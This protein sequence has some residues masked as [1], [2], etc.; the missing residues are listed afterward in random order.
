MCPTNSD[1]LPECGACHTPGTSLSR[2]KG[3]PASWIPDEEQAQVEA[4]KAQAKGAAGASGKLPEAVSENS[5]KLQ[6]L[7]DPLSYQ[8]DLEQLA[9]RNAG[10]KWRLAPVSSWIAGGSGL[11][12][13]MCGRALCVIGGPAT[14]KTAVC[15]A[16][17]QQLLGKRLESDPGKW[18][19]P[20]SAVHLIKYSDQRCIDPLNIVKSLVFQL[21]SSPDGVLKAMTE[22]FDKLYGGE[23]KLSDE[24]LNQLE[25]DV[26]AF[27]LTRATEIKDVLETAFAG[28]KG[29]KLGVKFV[30]P[31]DLR[32]VVYGSDQKKGHSHAVS[33]V[34]FSPD[35]NSLATGSWDNTTK[36]WGVSTGRVTSTLLGHT[37]YVN[38]VVFNKDGTMVATGASDKS[39]R[40]WTLS[41][42]AAPIVSP[43]GLNVVHTVEN[44]VGVWR[45]CAVLDTHGGAV[46]GVA[47]SPDGHRLA[48]AS[49]DKIARVFDI[50]SASCVRTL[51]GHSHVLL[52][53]VYTPDGRSVVTAS[54]DCT[55]K[56][57]DVSSERCVHTLTGHTSYVRGLAVVGTSS[58]RSGG[59]KALLLATASADA[60]ARVW[61]IAGGGK[62]GGA[63]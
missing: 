46:S 49:W 58:S 27:E 31:M 63:R 1:A 4:Q 10:V 25:N 15:A 55:A 48:T 2:F 7:L 41:R 14:G 43:E 20:Y 51:A 44:R 8:V 60:T 38:C 12:A 18:T 62:A 33:S 23:T 52:A 30:T 56:V 47:F 3:P 29:V 17:I 13:K 57:W 61:E 54:A 42:G 9:K 45:C 21:A 16:I 24:T 59:G 37:D 34:A 32:T 19:G 28:T 35:G 50:A 5:L 39:A 36:V 11:A 53:V 40:V 26:A 6:L 22:S